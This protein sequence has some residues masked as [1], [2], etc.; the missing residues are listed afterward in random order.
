MSERMELSGYEIQG[1]LGRGGFATVYRAR[2][3]AVGREV[4]LK[5]DSRLTITSSSLGLLDSFALHLAVVERT[6]HPGDV[7]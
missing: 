6:D 1:V 4:A 5:V 7:L 3:L 2:Q